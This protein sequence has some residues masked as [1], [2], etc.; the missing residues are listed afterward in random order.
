MSAAEMDKPR[1]DSFW[2][3]I[4][5]IFSVVAAAA[6]TILTLGP[7]PEGMTVKLDV[8]GLPT[9]NALFNSITTVLLVTGL[10]F[11]KQHRID[12][13]RRTMFGAFGTS[14]LFL[15]TYV[16]YHW[17]KDGPKKYVGDFTSFYYFILISHIILAVVIL[18]MALVALYR[19]WNGQ[20]DKHRALARVTMP[21]WLYVSATGVL[22]YTMLY[23]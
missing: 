11:I 20:I 2:L 21:L 1:N 7:R 17:F 8:S 3:T 4:I 6:I 9:V 14:A 16:I 15:V 5:I 18:P 23:W 10:V 13:H 19:G 22:I 12:A